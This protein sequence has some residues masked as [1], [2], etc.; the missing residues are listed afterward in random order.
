MP[1]VQNPEVDPGTGDVRMRT[2]GL[3]QHR[4]AQRVLL[5]HQRLGAEVVV[6]QRESVAVAH[7]ANRVLLAEVGGI[8]V[9][10]ELAA[11]R[12]ELCTQ[13]LAMLRHARDRAPRAELH[14]GIR[15]RQVHARA[16]KT[17]LN[18]DRPLLRRRQCRQRAADIEMPAPVIDAVH[19]SRVCENAILAVGDQR[20]L[21]DTVP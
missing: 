6:E 14:V 12:R 21:L 1:R 10:V 5:T 4:E 16:R 3:A 8:E 2:R 9:D 7:G 11:E 15:S 17:G 13:R 18:D 20:V 19:L